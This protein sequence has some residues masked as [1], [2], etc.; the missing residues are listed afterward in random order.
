MELELPERKEK[1]VIGIEQD[2]TQVV[3]EVPVGDHS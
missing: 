2:I 3:V 1:E